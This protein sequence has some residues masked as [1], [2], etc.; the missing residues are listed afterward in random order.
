MNKTAK[1]ATQQFVI[2]PAKGMKAAPAA[3]SFFLALSSRIAPQRTAAPAS[4]NI[5]TKMRVLDSVHEDGAKL[6]EMDP[7][8]V[9]ALRGEQPGVRIVPVVYYYP[10]I[11][12]R[13]RPAATAK[14]AASRIS[15]LTFT[16]VSQADQTP[17]AGAKV[18][19]FTDFANRV[20]AEGTANARGSV[21]LNMPAANKIER[22]YVYCEKGFWNVLQEDVTATASQ[23]VPM[24]PIDLSYTD[25]L[26]FFYPN[27]PLSVGQGITVGVID[28]GISTHPD[29]VINGGANTVTGENEN[30][31]RDNGEGH[32]THV[33]GIIAARGTPPAGVRGLAPG[34]TLR[35]YRVFGQGAPSASN[36]AIIKAID[37]AVA[38]GCDLI[39]MSLGGGPKDEATQSALAD[40]RSQGVLIFV[41]NGND[42]R[43]PVSFPASDTSSLAISA[44]GRIGTFPEGSS[45]FGDVAK[46]FGTDNKN[47]IAAFSNVGPETQLTAP[48]DGIISTF[49]GGYAVLD[50]TSMACPA[51]TGAAAAILA[52]LPAVLR[53]SRGQGRSD[54]MAQ[55]ISQQAKKLGFGAVFEGLGLL[56]TSG[57]STATASKTARVRRRI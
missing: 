30:D 11:A 54:A 27:S 56:Q 28:T 33:A 55:A 21:V 43:A 53:L 45:E 36:F 5:K 24:Q 49:P 35:S 44:F 42:N 41:A 2:L 57:S 40:A 12:S 4:S 20:G 18:V 39:N 3:Q 22:L 47:F 9:S 6:V 50:G 38:D 8:A 7:E 51:A 10:A 15:K 52:G 23:T 16:V 17:V 29:L 46:P 34:I 19:A 26:R 48:G 37:R 31:F 13:P 25:A 32:G 14:T 1:S